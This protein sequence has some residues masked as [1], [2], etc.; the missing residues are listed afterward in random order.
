MACLLLIQENSPENPEILTT[1]GLLYL[2]VGENYKAF[3]YFGNSL[4]FD[5]KN[6]KTILAAGSIIQDHSEVF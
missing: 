2:R 1:L 5:P 6:P 4:N 3:D